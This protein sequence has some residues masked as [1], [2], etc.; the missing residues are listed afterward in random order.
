MEIFILVIL[1]SLFIW[2]AI[3]G[4]M[5]E[6]SARIV[7]RN[8]IIVTIKRKRPW[9][10]I[11]KKKEDIEIVKGKENLYGDISG[12][13]NFDSGFQYESASRIVKAIE[14]KIALEDAKKNLNR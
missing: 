10:Y 11:L 8:L 7:S 9:S 12:W 5:G 4:L 3:V 14:M 6:L 13:I 2:R 1:V